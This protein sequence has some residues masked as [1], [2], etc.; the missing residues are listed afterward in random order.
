MAE[1][2][3]GR[4]EVP[5]QEPDQNYVEEKPGGHYYDSIPADEFEMPEVFE[6]EIKQ[7]DNQIKIVTVQVDKFKG[8]K[9]F[10]GGYRNQTNGMAYHTAFTQT[11]Q[12]PT[13]HP[14][15]KTR[16]IQTYQYNTKCSHMMREFGTQMEKSNLY[17]DKRNDKL[18][19][20]KPVYT[21]E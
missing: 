7:A 11:D 4:E 14:E 9:P 18:I 10:I 15:K 21:S 12:Q 16:E 6:V 1:E 3:I 2:V 8:R 20:P 5:Y 19:T 13:Y 17:I